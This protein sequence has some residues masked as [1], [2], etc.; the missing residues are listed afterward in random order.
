MAKKRLLW[1]E[2]T[3]LIPWGILTEEQWQK[4]DIRKL[5]QKLV[6]VVDNDKWLPKDGNSVDQRKL[7][8]TIFQNIWLRWAWEEPGGA[9]S[10]LTPPT[11]GPPMFLKKKKK[12]FN[13]CHILFK[14]IF[15]QLNLWYY[16]NI[17]SS[18]CWIFY[19]ILF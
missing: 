9:I 12:I 6:V 2:D 5:R 8:N 16:S 14:I 13:K 19:F 17:S 10:P 7:S 11:Q 15:N 3:T 4:D 18:A 1:L